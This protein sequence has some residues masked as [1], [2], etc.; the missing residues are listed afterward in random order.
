M[1]CFMPRHADIGRTLAYRAN[2]DYTNSGPGLLGTSVRARSSNSE[3]GHLAVPG[4][5]STGMGLP[6]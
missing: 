3:R 1:F 4:F 5:L 6:A 2:R